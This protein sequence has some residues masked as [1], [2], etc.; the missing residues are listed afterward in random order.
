MPKRPGC[1]ACILIVLALSNTLQA[2]PDTADPP[3]TG[4][5]SASSRQQ[6]TDDMA[7]TV[8]A[9]PEA[10]ECTRPPCPPEPDLTTTM[11]NFV[12][13][14]HAG[15]STRIEAMA[16]NLDGFFANERIFEETTESYLQISLNTVFQ[17]DGEVTFDEDIKAK[18]DLTKTKRKLKLLIESDPVSTRKDDTSDQPVDT[19]EETNYFLSIEREAKQFKNWDISPALGI[20]FRTPP[21]PFARVR[22]IR[23]FDIAPW[24]LR[25]SAN[26]YWFDNDG[27]G[28]NI[29]FELD[30]ALTEDV[31]FR[32]ASSAEWKELSRDIVVAEIFSFYQ[33]L[34]P[35]H[36]FVYEIGA[37][38]VDNP[39]WTI[40]YYVTRLRYRR[41]AYKNWLFIEMRPEVAFRKNDNFDADL[42]FLFRVETIF[43]RKY[44]GH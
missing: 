23:Y 6:A 4:V 20:R 14:A 24:L 22:A 12:D 36:N 42:S 39:D 43:G 40:D 30:R 38:G 13:R 5:V 18:I 9:D 28:R 32:S 7:G 3:E 37:Y 17:E 31:L 19:P 15:V 11:Q 1:T 33:Y 35:K 25:T 29:V 26:L 21:N 27:W 8:A 10:G 2:A 44:L 34:G 41:Q 16:Q